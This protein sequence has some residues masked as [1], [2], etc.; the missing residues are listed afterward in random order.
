M[1]IPKRK[2]MKPFF[3][4]IPVLFLSLATTSIGAAQ[5]SGTS[6]SLLGD[7]IVEITLGIALLVSIIVL[8]VLLVVL[9]VLKAF[10]N[11]QKEQLAEA[12]GEVEAVVEESAWKK[13]MQSLTKSVPLT[14]EKD[15]LTDHEYDGIRE[16]DNKLP[17]W[18]LAL[19]YITIVFGVA[20]LLHYHVFNTGLSQD[21]EYAQEMAMAEE[22]IKAY[23]ASLELSID[24]TNVEITTVEADLVEGQ[25]IFVSQCA[26]CHANDGGGGVGPNMTDQYWIHGGDIKDLFA[27]VKYGVPQKGMISWQS[28]LTPAQMRNV[29]SYILTLQGTTPENPKEP[30][31]ELYVPEV[32]EEVDSAQVEEMAG[33]AISMK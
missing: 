13:F 24:E 32:I 31:G 27:T 5:A 8:L 21:E 26:A 25:Q 1:T 23:Q 16:L 29:S 6:G 10:V 19:F 3:R 20:Y 11:L 9:N 33:E 12:K 15:V 28:Q 2:S 22:Q 18:W 7:Y 17:P 4:Y 30:Q 14:Q